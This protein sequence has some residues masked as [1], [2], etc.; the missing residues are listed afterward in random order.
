MVFG[1]T[2]RT[3]LIGNARYWNTPGRW[4]IS[5]FPSLPVFGTIV[6]APN[7]G[8]RIT[9]IDE[10]FARN[11]LDG[12]PTSFLGTNE[13]QLERYFQFC[14]YRLCSWQLLFLCFLLVILPSLSEFSFLFDTGE[15]ELR[16]HWNDPTVL[17]DRSILYY[18][19]FDSV[20]RLARE[21]LHGPLSQGTRRFNIWKSPPRGW[22]ERRRFCRISSS[23]SSSS[24]SPMD[25]V[26]FLHAVSTMP[27]TTGSRAI[28]W[29][30]WCQSRIHLCIHKCLLGF[31]LCSALFIQNPMLL[32]TRSGKVVH[33][34]EKRYSVDYGIPWFQ[35]WKSFY[36]NSEIK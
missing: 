19:S 23:A 2:E 12:Y 30:G 16:T 21:S 5:V 9:D 6:F 8:A 29:E 3:V 7:R 34:V 31:S 28:I 14:E 35:W 18:E 17:S 33:Y 4:L 27:P 26:S 24:S 11:L 25:H 32:V 13:I 15:H 10:L 36:N 22:K 20:S 1:R